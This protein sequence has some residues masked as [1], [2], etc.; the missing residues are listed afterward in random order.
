MQAA[1]H[2]AP[3]SSLA[4]LSRSGW[5]RLSLCLLLALCALAPRPSR[6]AGPDDSNPPATAEAPPADEEA[7]EAANATPT[8]ESD[9]ERSDLLRAAQAAHQQG[10]HE[11][12]LALGLRANAIRESAAVLRFIAEQYWQLGQS[13]EARTA[14]EECLERVSQEKPTPNRTAVARG[15]RFL[16]ENTPKPVE[17]PAKSTLPPPPPAERKQQTAPVSSEENPVASEAPIPVPRATTRPRPTVAGLAVVGLGASVVVAGAVA[18]LAASTRYRELRRSCASSC[19]DDATDIQ[20]QVQQL[21]R[22]ALGLVA[23]GAVVTATG[24][25]VSLA[26][27][28]SKDSGE[29]AMLGVRGRF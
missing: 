17:T 20:H 18:R 22:L 14:A 25:Y 4:A 16:V 2:A 15:C 11:E 19:P 13:S 3:W 27:P 28:L 10:Q 1:R 5:R 21:D 26:P 24:I 7:A 6:A 12:A 8:S 9:A 23:G 29:T